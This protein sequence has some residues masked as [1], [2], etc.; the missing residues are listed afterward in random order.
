MSEVSLL[1]E[2]FSTLETP[3]LFSR[4]V[5]SDSAAINA[6]KTCTADVVLLWSNWGTFLERREGAGVGGGGGGGDGIPAVLASLRTL[7]FLGA[8][9]GKLACFFFILLVCFVSTE[10]PSV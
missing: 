8:K 7:Y 2:G 3:K 6:A 1:L 10:T 9:R 4:W 5:T